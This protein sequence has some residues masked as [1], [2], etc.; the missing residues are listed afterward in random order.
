MGTVGVVKAIVEGQSRDTG[1][2]AQ[3][4]K[5]QQAHGDTHGGS[6]WASW[7]RLGFWGSWTEEENKVIAETPLQ[8]AATLCL[9]PTH[10]V[11]QPCITELSRGCGGSRESWQA[12]TAL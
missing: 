7:A 2:R 6:S 8:G 12:V 1:Q 4:H 10:S 9:T 3:Q 5:E 11:T